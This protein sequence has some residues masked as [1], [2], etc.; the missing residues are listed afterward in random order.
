MHKENLVD[1]HI[2]VFFSS[3]P[4]ASGGLCFHHLTPP[5]RGL[6]FKLTK[7]HPG[8]SKGGTLQSPFSITFSITHRQS[9]WRAGTS[10]T[11]I[12]PASIGHSAWCFI[13]EHDSRLRQK[14]CNKFVFLFLSKLHLQPWHL[15]SRSG[16]CLPPRKRRTS[17]RPPPP[18]SWWPPLAGGVR[19][20]RGAL[21]F[22]PWLDLWNTSF[23]HQCY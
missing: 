15:L 2:I 12:V 13:G 23:K 5:W 1:L 6:S 7:G 10:A 11:Q 19:T 4:K 22:T 9:S 18:G 8:R 17:S 14:L 20:R 3:M 21:G 16:G